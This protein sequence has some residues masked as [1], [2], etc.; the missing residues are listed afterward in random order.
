MTDRNCPTD[1]YQAQHP[2]PSR[3]TPYRPPSRPS[4]PWHPA[5]GPPAD[6]VDNQG[7]TIGVIMD[8]AAEFGKRGVRTVQAGI[9]SVTK[10][11]GKLPHVVRRVTGKDETGTETPPEEVIVEG[12]PDEAMK[13]Y[14]SVLVWLVQ[15]DDKQIDHMLQT[16]H[17]PAQLAPTRNWP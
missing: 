6:G 4:T 3:R 1:S 2:P 15:T 16:R 17:P 14:L 12:L 8:S 5:T 9:E 11:A 13:C 10:V 7:P